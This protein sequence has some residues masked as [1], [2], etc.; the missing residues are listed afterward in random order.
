MARTLVGGSVKAV[1]KMVMVLTVLLLMSSLAA[2]QT[3]LEV[4]HAWPENPAYDEWLNWME[5]TYE[6]DSPDVDVQFTRVPGIGPLRERL[7]VGAAGGVLP[8]VTM[9]SVAWALELYERGLLRSLNEYVR[10]SPD[11]DP[12]NFIPVTHKY[13]QKEGA[14][15]GIPVFTASNA[16][17]YNVRHFEESGLSTDPFALSD[18]NMWRDALQK[19]VRQNPD[20]EIVRGGIQPRGVG[21]IASL[22]PFLYANGSQIYSD[23]L[24]RVGFD[25][26]QG[27]EAFQMSID[28]F[29][30]L[31]VAGGNFTQGTASM[32]LAG[33][34][35]A[36]LVLDASPGLVLDMINLPPGPSGSDRATM[37]WAN[38]MAIPAGTEHADKA[39]ELIRVMTGVGSSEKMVELLDRLPSRMDYFASG[40]W[41][42]T[43]EDR[44][45]LRNTPS[46]VTSGGAYPFVELNELNRVINPLF[47]AAGNNEI[48]AQ[49]AIDRAAFEANQILGN[50]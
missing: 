12:A 37:T 34:W 7:I 3:R 44:P 23:D 30:N 31:D 15:F 43:A 41:A 5:E 29:G 22:G 47:T 25:N 33:D 11:A 16:L 39:W 19:L 36:K 17:L 38:M 13:S 35:N 18:W 8:H 14:V 24:T 32:W 10:L 49:E 28:I 40:H 6:R 9:T 21:N 20:G 1:A 26:P 27:V 4:W 45:Y 48:P 50:R 42:R 2:A 46:L